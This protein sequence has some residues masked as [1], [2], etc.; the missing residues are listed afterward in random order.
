[1]RRVALAMVCSLLPALLAAQSPAGAL[2]GLVSGNPRAVHGTRVEITRVEPEPIVTFDAPTDDR[3]RYRLDS[4]PPGSY[5][6]HVSSP[7]LDSLALSLP[8]RSVTI[9]ASVRTRA[10]VALPSG[11]ALRDAVCPGLVLEKGKGAIIGHAVD[12][13]TE[14]PLVGATVVVSWNELSVDRAT[15]R[16]TSEERVATLPTRARGEFRLCGV[17]TGTGLSL[18]LQRGDGAS[19]DV[20]LTVSDEEGA[21]V[22]DLSLSARATTAA[23][24]RGTLGVA[25]EVAED[26]GD[27]AFLAGTA[28]VSGTVRGFGGRPL[29]D[30]E[31]RIAGARASAVSDAEGRY[32]LSGL[33]AGTHM[34][35]ARRIGYEVFETPVELR[36]GRTAQSDVVLSRIVSLDSMRVVALSARYPQFD[37]NR[38]SNPFGIYL[39]PEELERRKASQTSEFLTGVRGLVISGHGRDARASTARGRSGAREC[40]GMQV[41]LDGRD[42]GL[43]LDDIPASSVGAIEIHTRGALAPSEYTIRG[44]CGVIAVWTKRLGDVRQRSGSK[45]SSAGPGE[46]PPP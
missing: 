2:E 10:D 28:V 1:M 33:P 14:R 39:G 36:A 29:A 30:A 7:L 26:T 44:S 31:L 15:L 40:T 38:R 22:R 42:Q 5:A 4:L 43:G 8:D 46:Q 45:E 6:L 23:G 9:T 35:V 32:S 37:F 21:V 41:L 34:L 20:R 25:R 27:V 13:D 11:T 24:T 17:P 3:G 18:Q 16:T 19:A 12:A